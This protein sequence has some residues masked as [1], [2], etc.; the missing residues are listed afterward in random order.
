MSGPYQQPLGQLDSI[1]LE[2]GSCRIIL[3]LTSSIDGRAFING[4]WASTP[5]FYSSSRRGDFDESELELRIACTR[6]EFRT[7]W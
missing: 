4:T 1:Y 5:A 7:C 3:T 2:H 6:T